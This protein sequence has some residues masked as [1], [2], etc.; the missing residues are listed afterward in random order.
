MVSVKAGDKVKVEYTGTLEDGTV[1]DSSDKH[2]D[3]LEFV[4][5]DGQIIKGFDDA[6]VGM[7]IG[8]EK[9]IK[10]PPNK[11]YGSCVLT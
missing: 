5:G 1:F 11:A 8:E 10:I 4:V 9:E 6:M 2:E 7:K 3:P